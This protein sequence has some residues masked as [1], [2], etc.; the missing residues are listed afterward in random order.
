MKYYVYIVACRDHSLYTG[1]TTD[2]TSRIQ[3]HNEGK[4]AKYTSSRHP[5]KLCYVE[6]GIGRSWATKREIEIKKMPRIRKLALIK[7]GGDRS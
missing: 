1:I 2:L 3:M 5:V 7:Q 6:E 4:G